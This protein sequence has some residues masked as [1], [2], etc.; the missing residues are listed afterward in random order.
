MNNHLKREVARNQALPEADPLRE[1][2]ADELMAHLH[3]PSVEKLLDDYPQSFVEA[4]GRLAET[5]QHL[6]R[7]V[8]QGTQQEAARASR[9]IAAYDQA[10]SFFDELESRYAAR[11]TEHS[12]RR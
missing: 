11:P 8:R 10:L 1:Q 4:R 2:W 6:E 7:V 5:R 9:A 3:Y 12:A